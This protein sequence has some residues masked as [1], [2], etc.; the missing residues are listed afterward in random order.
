MGRRRDEKKLGAVGAARKIRANR[1]PRFVSISRLVHAREHVFRQI[2][3]VVRDA[4][5]WIKRQAHGED[6]RARQFTPIDAGTQSDGVCLIGTRVEHRGEAVTREH[7]L[8]PLRKGRRRGARGIV[9]DFFGEVHVAVLKAGRDD[10]RT[11]RH[12]GILRNPNEIAR[13]DGE[14]LAVANEHDAVFDRGLVWR[15]VN[16]LRQEG[17]SFSTREPGGCEGAKTGGGCEKAHVQR[18]VAAGEPANRYA[19]GLL[20][21]TRRS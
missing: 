8:E 2:R 5:W 6:A 14:D 3:N 20:S 13:T 11:F 15:R 4:T 7:R 16:L 18:G 21:P 17:D 19:T 1:C 12:L 9:P 10:A